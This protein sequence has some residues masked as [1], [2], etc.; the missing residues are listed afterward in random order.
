MISITRLAIAVLLSATSALP[1]A[2]EK[3]HT[4][5]AE[6]A[7]DY[8]IVGGG[9]TG[10]VVANRLTEDSSSKLVF[11]CITLLNSTLNTIRKNKGP[12]RDD[13]WA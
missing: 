3:T 2:I 9:V 6:N 1:N 10:L 11:S 12:F 8:V 7:W 4:R 5:S 13:I